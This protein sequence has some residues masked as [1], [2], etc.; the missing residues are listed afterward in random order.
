MKKNRPLS[1]AVLIAIYALC[2]A[3]GI[4]LFPKLPFDGW[5]SLLITDVVCTLFVFGFS[6]ILDNASVYDPYWSVQP[7]VI[8]LSVFPYS[9]ADPYMTVLLVAVVLWSVRLSANFAY[10][11]TDFTYEDWRYRMLKEKT[12]V[13]YPVINLVGIHMVPTLVVYLAVLPAFFV[14]TE[15]GGGSPL[16]LIGALLCFGA[17]VLQTV[18]DLQMHSYRRTRK[19]TFIQQGLWRHSRH[20]N[21]L[22][23]ILMWWGVCIFALIYL[24]FRWYLAA[25][26]VA[27]TALFL[28]VSIPMADKRQ[29]RKDGFADYKA[30]TRALLP[31]PKKH[32]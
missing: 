14:M 3:L 8:L 25:G 26:A 30:R 6:L 31:I 32:R 15:G 27:N 1:F 10:T 4:I 18:A 16:S 11:F 17:V 21:Y 20:P 24:G 12:G 29:S 5:L 7:S 2:S 19:T 9:N 28:L 13:F 22:G 23:E